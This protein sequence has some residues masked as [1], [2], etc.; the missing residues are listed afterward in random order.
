MTKPLSPT[1]TYRTSD[2]TQ[3]DRQALARQLAAHHE[4]SAPHGIHEVHEVSVGRTPGGA[5]QVYVRG[6]MAR[7]DGRPHSRNHSRGLVLDLSA[8]QPEWLESVVL[9]ARLRLGVLPKELIR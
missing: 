1:L 3:V 5:L 6:R 8:K 9:D 4:P 2:L 7:A